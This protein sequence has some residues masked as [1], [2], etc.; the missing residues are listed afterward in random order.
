MPH[1]ILSCTTHVRCCVSGH[2]NPDHHDSSVDQWCYHSMV[3]WFIGFNSDTNN[4]PVLEN[5]LY[6]GM[7]IYDSYGLGY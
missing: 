4:K 2:Y 7:S 5:T 1:P 6:Q 3:F